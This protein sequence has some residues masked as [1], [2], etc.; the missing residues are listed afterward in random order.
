[1]FNDIECIYLKPGELYFADTGLVIHTVLGSC[2]SITMYC[3]R[4]KVG[5]MSHCMLPSSAEAA[6]NGEDNMKYVDCAVIYMNRRFTELRIDKR[7]TEVKLFGGSD[8]F[9]AK[10][11][12][13]T[14]GQRNIKASMGILDNMG[15]VLSASD[16]GGAFTR[17]LYFSIETG[18]VYQRKISRI[19][20]L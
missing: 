7:E 14:V 3:R 4:L 9:S 5:I 18:T 10:D 13:S 17:K 15:Y 11:A 12:A 1:M 6:Q 20:G 19:Q 8:M 16:T 2:V